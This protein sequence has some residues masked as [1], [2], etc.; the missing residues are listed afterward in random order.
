MKKYEFDEL[1]ERAF[2]EGY[3]LAQKEFGIESKIMGVFAP[4]AWQAKEAA[5]YAYEDDRNEYYRK[6]AGYA[7]KGHFTPITATIVKKRAE[8]MKK[9]GKSPKQ[10]KKYLENPGIGRIAGGLGEIGLTYALANN[11]D[12]EVR[13]KLAPLGL[14]FAQAVGLYDTI[15]DNRVKPKKKKKS[16]HDDD[17][18]ED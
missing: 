6:R 8:Q 9:E 1:V 5:K 16:D 2:C 18:D 7:L 14:N 12:I 10:I 17:D 3:E 4:G 11:D 15:A 13:T